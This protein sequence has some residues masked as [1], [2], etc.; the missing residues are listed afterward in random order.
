MLATFMGP[1]TGRE[2]ASAPASDEPGLRTSIWCITD[3]SR[4]VRK[5]W[6]VRLEVNEARAE[7][8][9]GSSLSRVTFNV[10]DAGVVRPMTPTAEPAVGGGAVSARAANGEQQGGG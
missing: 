1:R 10:P 2:P 6:S 8:E 5:K 7:S 3:G 9:T 4:P